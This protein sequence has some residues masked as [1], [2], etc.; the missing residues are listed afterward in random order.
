MRY[1][2]LLLLAAC[3]TPEERA[4]RAIARHGP[5]CERLGY[6]RGTKDWR[7]CIASR[8]VRR[9]MV[10]NQVGNTTICN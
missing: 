5:Y 6:E 9:G 8:D 2:I 1:L 10:C 4:D 7:D 3:A